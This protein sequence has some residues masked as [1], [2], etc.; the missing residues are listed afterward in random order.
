V[1]NTPCGHRD[2]RERVCSLELS[3]TLQ[4]KARSIAC[5]VCMS[6]YIDIDAEVEEGEES[7]ECEGS[8]ESVDE[9]GLGEERYGREIKE[10]EWTD[11]RSASHASD[12]EHGLRRKHR[13]GRGR[14]KKKKRDFRLSCR[15]FA[16][17]YPQCDIS[18]G[19][20]DK[21]WKSKYHPDE[22]VSARERHEDGG[23]HLHLFVAYRRRKDVRSA[24][25]FDMAFE[26]K[27]YHPNVKRVSDKEGWLEYL[28]K[29]DDNG[30]AEFLDRSTRF[31]PLQERV[32]DS[33]RKYLDWQWREQFR[34]AASRKEPKYPIVLACEGKSYEML[35]PDPRIKKRSWWIVARPNAGKTR[36]VNRQFAGIRCYCPRVGKYPFEGYEDEDIIIY[37]DREG[38]TFQEFAS[39]LNTWDIIQPVAGEIRYITKNWKVGHTRS[40]IVLSN[41]TIEESIPEEDHARMKKR[42]I[43]IVNPVLL[44]PEEV[45]DDEEEKQEINEEY[46]DFASSSA[47]IAL[48]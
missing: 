33:K 13:G 46:A 41:K 32:G 25:Y 34:V 21:A 42:F 14:A 38:V 20:F 11:D 23:Y 31:D 5:A 18:R 8:T 6:R 35:K 37:D 16:I 28:A 24:R 9:E 17:T 36:W 12:E 22:Y 47:A 10:E 3:V 2:E 30:V 26:G 48:Y 43:Q 40:C 27:T 44:N 4:A 45:S 1:R 19:E 39:V 29:E 15:E 7:Q